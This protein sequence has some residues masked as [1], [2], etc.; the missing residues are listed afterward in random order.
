MDALSL[1][2]TT[3]LYILSNVDQYPVELLGLLPLHWR[4]S[5]LEAL[6]P[7][8]LYQLEGT[9]IAKGIE[10]DEVWGNHSKQQDCVWGEYLND[11]RHKDGCAI[12]QWEN[13]QDSLNNGDRTEHTGGHIQQDSLNNGDRIGSTGIQQDSL[14]DGDQSRSETPT[15]AGNVDS[16]SHDTQQQHDHMQYDHTRQDKYKAKRH[17]THHRRYKQDARSRFVNYL[18]HLLFNEMNR[19]YACKRVTELLHAIHVDTL[20]KTVANALVYGHINSLFMY[21]PPY[22]LIPFRCPNL[23]ERELYWLLHG[24]KMLPTSLELYVYNIDSSPLWTQEVIS[25]EMMRRLFS[26]LRFLRLYNHMS[27]TIQL[28]EI[29]NAVTHSSQ[30]KDQPSDMGSLKHLEFL[31]VDDRHLSA[32]V[33]LLS[34]PKGYSSLTSITI[35]MSKPVHYILAT[36]HLGP[37]VRHQLSSLQHLELA[38]FS[39]SISKNTIHMCDYMFFYTLVSFILKPHFRTLTLHG[40]TDLPWKM[41]KMLLEANLRTVPSH[42][43]TITFRDVSVTTRGE[44]PF[45][46]TDGVDSDDEEENQFY[47][48]AERKCLAYKHLLFK[49]SR[50]PVEVLRWFETTERVYVNTLE[51]SDVKFEVSTSPVSVTSRIAGGLRAGLPQFLHKSHN[52][53]QYRHQ[54]QHHHRQQSLEFYSEKD[55]K[56]RLLRHRHF[57]YC[58]FKWEDVHVENSCVMSV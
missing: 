30:Y 12:Q 23:T 36:R 56:A 9:A 35:A 10:T 41:L 2:D 24:N 32:I 58:E 11:G 53:R 39:C 8:R 40:L 38:G 26:Q 18:S 57:E 19:D 21:Q 48:A 28:E 49:S 22:Y 45:T 33:P 15:V 31:R 29:V 16:H 47:P 51:F 50:V 17:N 34:A 52:N 25:Q 1:Q 55:L 14:T 43:Q 37:I 54:Q 13:L 4:R 42:T 5:L 46:N 20:E 6:P 7:F 44:L 3:F 27:K